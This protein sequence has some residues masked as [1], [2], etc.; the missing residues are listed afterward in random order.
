MF[1]QQHQS[2]RR[3]A[4]CN[5]NGCFSAARDVKVTPSILHLGVQSAGMVVMSY[6]A[7]GTFI[8]S[9]RPNF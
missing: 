3:T 9:R 5:D 4:S 2:R 6:V 8:I 1:S 7:G